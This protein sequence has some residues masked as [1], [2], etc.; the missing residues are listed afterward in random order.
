MALYCQVGIR[1]RFGETLCRSFGKVVLLKG[2]FLQ[3]YIY[4]T[5][6]IQTRDSISR[7]I[8]ERLK[9]VCLEP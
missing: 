9:L 7:T 6:G 3:Q 8:E 2:L 5:G 4:V 1:Q